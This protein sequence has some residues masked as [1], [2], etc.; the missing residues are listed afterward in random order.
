MTRECRFEVLIAGGGPAGTVAAYH[1]ARMGFNVALFEIRGWDNVW[2]KPCGDAIGAHHFPNAG[3]PEPPSEVI[4]NKIDGVLI[5][6]PSLETVYRVRG[7][8][9]IIDRRGLGRWL[10]REAERRGAQIFLESSVEAPIVENGRVAGLRVRLKSG[11]HLE[12]RGNIVI[13]A[14]G[15]SMVVKRGLPRDWPV[16]ERLDMKDTNIAYREVQELSDEVEEPNYIRIYIN[17]EIAPGGYWWLFP[18]GKNVINIGLG[19]QGGVGN[20]HP[21]QQFTQLYERGLAPPPRRVIEAGGAVVPTRRPADTLVGP[22]LLVIGDAGFTVNPVH[23]GGIGYAF[24]AARLAAEAYKEA[25]DKGCFSEE[26]LW[27]LNT[28]YMKSLGAKQAA[29]DI[30]RLFLQRLSNDDIEYG[31]SQR[32][33]PESDVYFTSTTGE[34]RLSVVEKAMIILRGLRRPSLLL[35]LKLV[36]EYMEKVRKLYHAYPEDPRKLAQW[37]EQ[38]KS[39]FN[40]FLVKI[41]R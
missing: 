24:Y 23:G 34:L 14:T 17:Q 10:L 41:S 1:L 37:R 39:L 4:H 6:S 21:R 5:Y 7:E 18:E 30:F 29:L 33:M 36:A 31:M 8:G 38:V 40:E 32:I 15:Y 19:V 11:E 28:R 35:K 25:H 3:L 2:G 13:E 27:S 12:C 22:G 20:P 9:Y 16:A 26:C